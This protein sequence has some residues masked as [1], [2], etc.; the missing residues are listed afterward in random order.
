MLLTNCC[1]SLKV[2]AAISD[3]TLLTRLSAWSGTRG[4]SYIVLSSSHSIRL[5]HAGRQLGQFLAKWPICLQ[6]KQALL[7]FPAFATLALCWFGW[8]CLCW[9]ENQLFPWKFPP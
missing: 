2:M 8:N 6:L 3:R 5:A 7:P 1:F 4:S 9:L